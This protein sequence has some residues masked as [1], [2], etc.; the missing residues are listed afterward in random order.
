MII[1]KTVEQDLQSKKKYF[2]H[3]H[4]NDEFPYVSLEISRL[5]VNARG[6]EQILQNN[7]A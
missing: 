5:T 2:I 4:V 7:L 3:S 6:F 1:F